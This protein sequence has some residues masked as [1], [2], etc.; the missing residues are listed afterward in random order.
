MCEL[1]LEIQHWH[2]LQVMTIPRVIVL[3]KGSKATLTMYVSCRRSSQAN[4][5]TG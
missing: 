2:K 4:L 3:V 5:R 1:G